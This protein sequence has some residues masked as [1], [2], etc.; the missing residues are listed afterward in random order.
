MIC[1]KCR[2]SYSSPKEKHSELQTF[3]G[4]CKNCGTE[5]VRQQFLNCYTTGLWATLALFDI[6][7]LVVIVLHGWLL[8]VSFT[9]LTIVIQIAATLIIKNGNAVRYFDEAERKSKTRIQRLLGY[10]S[11]AATSTVLMILFTS[12]I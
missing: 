10:I 5:P 11:G 4:L 9:V 8:A 7:F 3:R 12:L 2:T 6:Y 1:S